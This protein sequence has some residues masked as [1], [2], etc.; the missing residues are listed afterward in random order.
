MNCE[1]GRARVCRSEAA[2]KGAHLNQCE[3]MSDRE[4]RRD[5]QLSLRSRVALRIKVMRRL[6]R[7]CGTGYVVLWLVQGLVGRVLP[8]RILL[9]RVHDM[10]GLRRGFE[11]PPS[12]YELRI[13]PPREVVSDAFD[14]TAI[15]TGTFLREALERGDELVA[16]YENE[17]IVSYG[18]CSTGPTPFSE[19][20][21]IS[22]SPEYVYGY[23]AHTTARHRGK[24]LHTAVIRYAGES[25]AAA[26]GKGMVAFVDA[27]NDRSL[28]S[29]AR[30]GHM[31]R[32]GMAIVWAGRKLR[33]WASPLCRRVGFS[34]KRG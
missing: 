30:V 3:K 17:K 14:D 10:D 27:S 18:W 1:S 32:T 8:L 15:R 20:L 2:A 31:D 28:I 16:A 7:H 23:R 13:I 25:V 9:V 26:R 34:L 11:A 33:Y 6:Y 12:G 24:G 19:D 29:E 4:A 21:T 22:F 5:D